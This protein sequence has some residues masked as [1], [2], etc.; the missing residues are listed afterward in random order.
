MADRRLALT[1]ALT[2]ALGCSDTT[3]VFLTVRAGAVVADHLR[4][5]ARASDGSATHELPANGP[6]GLI[7]WPVTLEAVLPASIGSVT[8]TAQALHNGTVTASGT[9]G[10]LSVPPHRIIDGS[11]DL[12]AGGAGSDGG[13]AADLAGHDAGS[14]GGVVGDGGIVPGAYYRTLTVPRGKVNA[15]DG[16]PTLRDYPLLVTLAD[17]T[18]RA[19]AAGGHVANSDGSDIRFTAG[20]ATCGLAS[21]CVLD[22]EVE[23]YDGNGGVL[24]AWVRLPVLNSAAAASDTA[25]IIAYG[26]PAPP[27]QPSAARV[28]DSSF[29]GVWHLA[30]GKARDSTAGARDGTPSGT[31][32]AGGQIAG[33][34]AFDGA[35]ARVDIADNAVF[36]FGA[37]TDFTI[38][39][40]LQSSQGAVV[41]SPRLISKRDDSAPSQGYD[42]VLHS[43]DTNDSWSGVLASAG[44]LAP[45]HGRTNIADGNWHL[46]TLVRKGTTLTAFEDGAA[47]SPTA[48]ASGA[49]GNTLGLRLG[50][51]AGAT[52]AGF[53]AG[54]E[55]EVRISSVARSPD[56]I[57][58]DYSSQSMPA[59]FLIVGSEIAP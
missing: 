28:W 8:F 27:G 58:T 23:R 24:V 52:P 12:L 22:H 47:A 36:D 15:Q 14:G 26:S 19:V 1:V 5:T 13:G 46:I 18:L 43:P 4:L 29:V 50:A 59:T 2:A 21:T 57:L 34:L 31:S 7:A 33:A 49:I 45:E 37:S 39:L 54:S 42:L 53:F 16:Q 25:F 3:G 11:I 30:D 55:D 9:S 17:P 35:S 20:G 51:E 6:D 38:S 41:A 10:A 56:W 48:I 44:T 40:W 32:V